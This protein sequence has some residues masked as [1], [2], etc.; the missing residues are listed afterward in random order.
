ME[1]KASKR[2]RQHEIN[3]VPTTFLETFQNLEDLDLGDNQLSGTIPTEVVE[4]PKLRNL[5]LSN[6]KING[7][8]T[9]E[10][11]NFQ[12]LE[13]LD[14]ITKVVWQRNWLDA[15]PNQP[16]SNEAQGH[17]TAIIYYLGC[18][19]IS[20]VW[21]GRFNKEKEQSEK[22]L[23]EEVFSVWS[24]DGKLMFENIIEA[25]NNF[26]YRYLIRVRGQGTVYKAELSS[27]QVYAVKKLYLETDGEKPN[28]KAFQNEIQALTEIWHRCS[29]D[30]ILI[31]DAKAA[32]FD[33]EKRVNIVKG[34]AN[35]LSYLHHDCSPPIIHRD[36]SS[37]NVLLDSQYET[38]VSDFGTAKI[39]KPG[40]NNWTTFA[41]TFG[42][43][44][45]ELAQTMEVTE[46]C[47]VFSLGVLCLEI[48][49]GKHPGDL[50]SS[51]LSSTSA[52]VT[53]NLLLLIDVLDQRP[54]QPLKINCRGC[55]FGCK[56]GTFLL[57]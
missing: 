13:S 53:Y 54:S 51:L 57:E 50:I 19:S 30:Q 16:Q 3:Q 23:S 34:V 31:N 9:I 55:H 15:F 41:G 44:A 17:S 43:A 25:T 48:I 14:L 46:K 1:I 20:V 52:T 36:V 40:S 49:M 10:F 38:H 7:S 37:K 11:H 6:D 39:L 47:D 12:A 35:A 29:L 27:C 22:A 18:S 56:L 2:I 26:D 32:A 42:Y 28:I 21:G 45:P 4:L 24:H 5:N 8:I 33:W